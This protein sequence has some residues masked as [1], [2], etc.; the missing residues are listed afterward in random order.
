MRNLLSYHCH[1]FSCVKIVFTAS[2]RRSNSLF[3]LLIDPHDSPPRRLLRWSHSRS[4]SRLE[5]SRRGRAHL[6]P[7]FA[8]FQCD[9]RYSQRLTWN[10]FPRS[11]PNLWEVQTDLLDGS[12]DKL[13]L[14]YQNLTRW[15]NESS[16]VSGCISYIDLFMWI[17]KISTF[18]SWSCCYLGVLSKWLFS[19]SIRVHAL[20]MCYYEQSLYLGKRTA[21]GYQNPSK[22]LVQLN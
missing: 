13:E 3:C 9:V 16:L 17:R 5:A 8:F 18:S 10:V 6:R 21:Q 15:T 14:L 22:G 4:S 7:V 1:L 2:L 12:A 20:W 11:A 19:L